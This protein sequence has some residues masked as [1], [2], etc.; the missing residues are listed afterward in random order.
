MDKIAARYPDKPVLMTSGGW[1]GIYGNHSYKAKMKWSEESQADYLES[2]IDLYIT[3]DY[4][5]GQIVWTFNDFR[6]SQWIIDGVARWTARS[7][8]MNHKGVLDFYRRPKLSYYR[9]QE[10]FKKWDTKG[11]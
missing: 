8:G 7:A 4:I 3:K 6:V 1:E 5:I 9:L 2:L 10:A 11:I